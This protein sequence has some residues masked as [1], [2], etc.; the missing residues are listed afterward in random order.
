MGMRGAR[1]CRL[2]SKSTPLPTRMNTEMIAE[3]RALL[4]LE[5]EPIDSVRAESDAFR[6]SLRA[7]VG[8]AGSEGEDSFDFDVCS[9]AWLDAQLD[10]DAVVSGRFLLIMRVFD[11]RRIENYVRTRIAQASG[12]DWPSVAAKIARW[13]HWE[14]EDYR[15]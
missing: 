8:S 14:F 2:L 6:I 4:T 13:S 7:L 5:H 1:R 10:G 9:P 11:A 15:D 3:L 12:D